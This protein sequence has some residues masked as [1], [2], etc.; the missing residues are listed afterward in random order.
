MEKAFKHKKKR[1]I[2]ND[3]IIVGHAS[4]TFRKLC[5]RDSVHIISPITKRGPEPT[6]SALLPAAEKRS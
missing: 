5:C 4:S 6:S 3:D 1:A 2:R